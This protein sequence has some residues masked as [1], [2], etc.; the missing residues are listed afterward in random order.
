MKSAIQTI[1]AAALIA[2]LLSGCRSNT[3][4]TATTIPTTMPTTAPTTAPTTPPTTQPTTQSTVAPTEDST[5]PEA[6]VNG[7]SSSD[8][9]KVTI[10]ETQNGLAGDDGMIPG[11]ANGAK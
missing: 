5:T 2:L 7:R 4:N 3:A 10:P 1:C 8:T 6:G 11:T 9:A